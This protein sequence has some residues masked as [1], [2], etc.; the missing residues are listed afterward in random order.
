MKRV[1]SLVVGMVLTVGACG[2][3]ASDQATTTTE[4]PTTSTT[5]STTTAAGAQ[6][7]PITVDPCTL[8]TTEEVA[9]AAG[10]AVTEVGN[11]SPTTCIFDFGEEAGVSIFL[12][13]DD[14]QGGFG[15]PSSLFE[16][17]VAL[18]ADGS[19]ETISDLGAAAV[20]AQSYR[21]L[22]V[23]AGD[24]RF[25]ALGVNGGYGQLAEPRDAFIELAGIAAGRL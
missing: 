13:V 11:E 7:T 24:G 9:A 18:V 8:V 16:N 5:T 6:V 1:V 4:T 12:S 20:F 15:A 25:F 2:G 23:D 10:L 14:G 17:Y 22:A 3:Q 19:A 21:G